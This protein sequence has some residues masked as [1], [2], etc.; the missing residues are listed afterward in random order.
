MLPPIFRHRG[1]GVFWL[2]VVLSATGA[3]ASAAANLWQ[4]QELTN[5]TLAVGLVALFE[6]VAIVGLA[7]IGGSVAD[8]L[9]RRRLLQVAQ[10]SSM[11]S[12][13]ALA[14]LT[15]AHVITPAW[16]YLGAT[17]VAA[18]AT[19]DTP[20]RQSLVPAVVPRERLVDAFSLLVPGMH[21][22]RLIGPAIAGA[23]ISLWGAGSVYILDAATY[24]VLV[25]TLP[26]IGFREQP[27][28]RRKALW[29]SVGE[30]FQ[31]V[32][33][34]AVI[35]QLIAL[36]LA[37][38]LFAGYRVLLPAIARDIFA[39]GPVGYGFLSAAPALG[40]VFGAGT[41][42]RL[43]TLSRRGRLA[44]G[45]AVGYGLFVIA[46]GYVPAFALAVVCAGTIGFF[47]S[48][49][50]TIRHATLQGATPD[51]LR[52]RVTSA[53][54]MFSRGGT[55]LGQAQLG[56]IASSLGPSLALAL[57]G[58]LALTSTVA[59]A[60]RGQAVRRYDIR[61]PAPGSAVAAS[62]EADSSE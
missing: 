7:P 12:S 58:V 9:P 53:Y 20:A 15:F 47:D 42:Y 2:G 6:A 32:R 1:F 48:M 60:A 14:G 27:L 26:F 17:V 35:W 43:R 45:A 18:A 37:G 34:R 55:A 38:T 56:A 23:L 52:G 51:H 46:L 54:Q 61:L 40:A 4:V 44:I 30:G 21:L 28:S 50:A 33:Q 22:A 39:V 5:S 16:I 41:A 36:D 49:G 29:S 31:Y 19:F 8:W 3:R 25:V 11:I 10:A 59:I 62:V 57:G 24:G 13:I